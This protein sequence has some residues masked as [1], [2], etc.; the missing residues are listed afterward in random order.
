MSEI[1]RTSEHYDETWYPPRTYRICRLVLFAGSPTIVL[2]FA[3]DFL[4][5]WLTG[6]RGAGVLIVITL[7]LILLS[8]FATCVAFFVVLTWLCPRCGKFLHI[9]WPDM[10]SNPF[11]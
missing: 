3:V 5:I 9:F 10:R 1:I 7:P 6:G 2:L 4:T 8:M 11:S